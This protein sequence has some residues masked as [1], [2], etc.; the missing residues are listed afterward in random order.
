MNIN[1]HLTILIP[2][3]NRPKFLARISSFLKINGLDFIIIDSSV[4]KNDEI[5]NNPN[6][7]WYRNFSFYQKINLGLQK[8]NTQFTLLIA[9]DDFISIKTLKEVLDFLL[10]N[11]SYSSAQG[12]F[13]DFWYNDNNY[14]DI[15][16]R[17]PE[18]SGLLSNISN[19]SFRER[20][21]NCTRP[22]MH[23]VY[24]VHRTDVLKTGVKMS[25]K[26]N[27]IILG[28]ISIT[29]V[30][31]LFGKH[32]MIPKIYGFRQIAKMTDRIGSNKISS[33]DLIK[34]DNI[35]KEFKLWKSALS[36]LIIEKYSIPK[37]EIDLI[38]DKMIKNYYNKKYTIFSLIK[39][40]VKFFIPNVILNKSRHP[41]YYKKNWP[42][43]TDEAIKIRKL[44]SKYPFYPWTNSED[45][46]EW[47]KIKKFLNSY[48]V[49]AEKTYKN[50]H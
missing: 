32:K 4:N 24:A 37:K 28:E 50:F 18:S 25:M 48:G 1:E 29:V 49:V 2:T 22:Y 26:A 27:S 19:N 15:C 42:P 38:I 9:D 40:F 16:T 44:T 5:S 39:N 6:Y 31:A 10:K 46:K 12:A 35:N 36:Q 45:D 13:L 34:K 41:L 3:H 30:D 17:Y 21:I 14:L 43:T 11:T 47:I 23:H 8:V 7:Y 33:R 20:L